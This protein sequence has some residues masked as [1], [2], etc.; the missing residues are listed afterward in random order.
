MISNSSFFESGIDEF[1]RLIRDGKIEENEFIYMLR[2][3]IHKNSDFEQV[4]AEEARSEKKGEFYTLSAKGVSTFSNGSPVEFVKLNDWLIERK[5][6]FELTKVPFFRQ[7]RVWKTVKMW[8]RNINRYRRD[9][10]K[11]KLEEKLYSADPSY[12]KVLLNH[13]NICLDIEKMKFIDIP[14]HI[15]QLSLNEFIERQEKRIEEVRVFIKEISKNIRENIN[16]G[17]LAI[18]NQLREDIVMGIDAEK[19]YGKLNLQMFPHARKICALYEKMGFPENMSYGQRSALRKECS[20]Y[21]RF[22]YLADFII[23]ESLQNLY[24]LSVRE[25]LLKIYEQIND[26]EENLANLSDQSIQLQAVN[27]KR[28]RLPLFKIDLQMEVV[29]IETSQILTLTHE[30][31]PRKTPADEFHPNIHLSFESNSKVLPATTVKDLEK[32]WLKLYPD[33]NIYINALEN[34]VEKGLESLKMIERGSR[35]PDI[36]D[37]VYALED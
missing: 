5:N 26:S 29:S 12:S 22:S 25:L 32:T 18:M 31:F 35:H 19:N 21:I 4:S 16:S 3:P 8:Q 10:R 14:G 15:D 1:I 27:K 7:F 6:F 20:R 23:L 17:I 11:K 34:L 9:R 13:R 33:Q 2:V 24:L 30:F 37:F 28:N 36:S